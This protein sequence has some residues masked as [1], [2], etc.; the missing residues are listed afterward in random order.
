MTKYFL[1]TSVIILYTKGDLSTI[2]QIDSLEG[3][4]TSGFICLA[5]L[6]E[7]VYRSRNPA[8]VEAS[9]LQFFQGLSE[10]FA[11][12]ARIPKLFGQVRAELRQKGQTID[13]IDIFIAATCLVHNLQLV[14]LN[15]KHF[16]RIPNLKIASI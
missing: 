10:V 5:E 8:K 12:D 15:T 14:T 2:S 11:I 9:F 3:E 6:Y 7:G 16:S 1:D 4:L 13:D